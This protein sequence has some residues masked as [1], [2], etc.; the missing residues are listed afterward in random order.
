MATQWMI[1]QYVLQ[2]VVLASDTQALNVDIPGLF[3]LRAHVPIAS[4]CD[5]QAVKPRRPA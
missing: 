5:S 3:V 1:Q 4:P 2:E